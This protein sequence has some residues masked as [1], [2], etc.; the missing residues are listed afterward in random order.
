L[1]LARASSFW[2]EQESSGILRIPEESGVN[3]GIPAGI[4]AK[5][6]CKSKKNRNSCD[7]LQNHVPVKKSSG[8]RRI[9][10]KSSGILSGTVFGSKK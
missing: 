7:P 1:S 4:P 2:W 9:K 3:T 8:K 10:K 6:S 5:N